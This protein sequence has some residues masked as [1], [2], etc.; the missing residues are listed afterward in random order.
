MKL[1]FRKPKPDI[2][3]LPQFSSDWRL[4]NG[5]PKVNPKRLEKVI[6]NAKEQW[7]LMKSQKLETEIG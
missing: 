5:T 7:E 3:P 6:E 1:F 4:L 2:Q